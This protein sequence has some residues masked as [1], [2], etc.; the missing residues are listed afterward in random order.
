MEKTT[1]VMLGES[2]PGKSE[3]FVGVAPGLVLLSMASSH[4]GKLIANAPG[5]RFGSDDFLHTTRT[6]P[7]TCYLHTSCMHAC[8][9]KEEALRPQL[10]VSDRGRRL[11]ARGDVITGNFQ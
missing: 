3:T 5:S 9:R 2:G 1:N 7:N 6:F 4:V 10:S 11:F 8:M